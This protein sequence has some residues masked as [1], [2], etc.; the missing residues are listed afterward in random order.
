MVLLALVLTSGTFAF[1]YSMSTGTTLHATV[2]G[3]SLT[4]YQPSEEQPD[5]ESILPVGEYNSEYLFPNAVG[6]V[7][8]GEGIREARSPYLDSRSSSHDKLE[9]IPTARNASDADH[10]DGDGAHDLPDDTQRNG[11]Q[12]R[13]AQTACTVRQT[14]PSSVPA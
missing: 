6:D 8:G 4:T 9:R 5:W 3:P 11:S 12:R 1:T 14:R 7:L 13:P 2:A 10:R